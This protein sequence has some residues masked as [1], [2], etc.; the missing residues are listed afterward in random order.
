MVQQTAAYAGKAGVHQKSLAER[1]LLPY[2][3][4]GAYGVVNETA[5]RHTRMT[6]A[7]LDALVA[8]LWHGTAGLNTHSKMGHQPLLLLL[9]EYAPGYRLGA[10]PRRL[11][12]N[13]A[14]GLA[15][16]ALRSPRDFELDLGELVDGLAGF[17]H[18][19]G[20]AWAQ[21]PRLRCRSGAQPGS[22]GTL[23]DQAGVPTSA[24]EL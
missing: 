21:D 6:R 9:A 17:A 10:L 4:I 18:L 1:W 14:E 20:V 11:T 3:L 24:L 22:L 23:L 19:K 7:D 2:A 16:T 12:L 5:A 15:D 13:N 8:G